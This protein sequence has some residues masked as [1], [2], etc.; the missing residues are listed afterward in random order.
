MKTY[1]INTRLLEHITQACEKLRRQKTEKMQSLS[2]K[3]ADMIVRGNEV[4]KLM[5]QMMQP[6][7]LILKVTETSKP[8]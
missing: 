1:K 6:K 2:V 4:T 5:K 7:K 3:R 8:S